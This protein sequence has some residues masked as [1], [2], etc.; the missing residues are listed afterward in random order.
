MTNTLHIIQEIGAPCQITNPTDLL[1]P[2]FRASFSRES[3]VID[4]GEDESV[5]RN[6]VLITVT[7]PLTYYEQGRILVGGVRETP[8]FTSL[9]RHITV[10]PDGVVAR[11]DNAPGHVLVAVG[12]VTRSVAIPYFDIGESAIS[13][14]A[15][16]TWLEGTAGENAAQGI[17]SRIA[18]FTSETAANGKL[19]FSSQNHAASSY[20]RNTS[21]WVA[22]LDLTCA[23]PWN[24]YDANRRAGTLVTPR[25]VLGA[26]HYPL[27]VG[28]VVRFVTMGNVVVNRTIVAAVTPPNYVP[29][30]PDLMLYVLD[31]DVPGTIQPCKLLPSNWED[32]F[33]EINLGRPPALGL[34]Q[35][36]KAL[37]TD[38]TNY[39]EYAG[40]L[41]PMDSKRV[42]FYEN[43][44]SGDSG[45]PAFVL[46][47]DEP[48]LLTVWTYGG[49]GSGTFVSG[50]LATLAAMI[51][52]ADTQ[53]GNGGTGHT[54]QFADLSGFNS[55]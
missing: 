44:I 42:L 19:I 21:S 4:G 35:E 1:N 49:P 25:H 7:E 29:Y 43:V 31:S 24:S 5:E 6:D 30:Y 22:G 37:I 52:T 20:T 48:C 41:A 18:S 55:Y 14:D 11:T 50:H 36:E 40:F 27:P 34:D 28:T 3:Y 38:W 54:L 33:V 47:N 9:D 12:G 15:T 46:V 10:T 26:V 51:I 16:I 17:D 8:T 39:V 32:Y 23:S 45:N 2:A 13:D 53:A